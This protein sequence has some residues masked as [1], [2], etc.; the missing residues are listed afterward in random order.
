MPI[1]T[2]AIQSSLTLRANMEF[3]Q[4]QLLMFHRLMQT[5]IFLE[6][7][8]PPTQEYPDGILH[9]NNKKLNFQTGH[10]LKLSKLLEPNISLNKLKLTSIWEKHEQL[11]AG[12]YIA[13][14]FSVLFLLAYASYLWEDESSISIK[15][16]AISGIIF[17]ITGF[18]FLLDPEFIKI[19]SKKEGTVKPE[20]IVFVI[21][22]LILQGISISIS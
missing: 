9:S 7:Y 12:I 15:L 4:V 18:V 2:V 20:G 17:Q 21:L 22:G 8:I 11:I 5:W 3:L 16:V 13:T 14:F 1:T 6:I 10:F 19:K